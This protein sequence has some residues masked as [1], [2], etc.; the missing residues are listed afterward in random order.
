MSHT[1]STTNYNLPQFITTDKPAWLTDVNNAYATIDTGMHA[2]KTAADSAQGDATQALTDAG[3]AATAAAAAD[4]K[5]SGAVASIADTF[6]ATTVYSVGDKVM[7]NSLLYICSVAVTTPG[8]WTGSA[9]WNRAT[10]ENIINDLSAADIPIA[11]GSSTMTN[12][13]IQTA[14]GYK[15]GDTISL[16]N[17]W[18]PCVYESATQ[19]R[20]ILILPK[21]IREC[22]INITFCEVY[23]DG[24]DVVQTN[25]ISNTNINLCP[26][27]EIYLQINGSFAGAPTAKAGLARISANII[28]A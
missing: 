21:Q 14:N 26:P 12:E 2:A 8:P 25:N 17:Y 20:A 22:S 10:V 13:A 18:V 9:N 27:N 19:L 23:C 28:F 24:G 7:Y 3:N 1:N 16:V 5:G 15:T 4:A 6:D 11:D